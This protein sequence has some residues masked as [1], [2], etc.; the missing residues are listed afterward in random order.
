MLG[1]VAEAGAFEFTPTIEFTL[2]SSAVNTNTTLRTVVK[3]DTGEEELKTVK[4]QVPAEFNL[5]L[6]QQLTNG[7]TLGTGSI[8]I[9]V[10]PRCRGAGPLSAPANVPVTIKERDR[11]AAETSSG[12]VAI[13]VV[14]IQGVTSIPLSVY[15]SKEAGWRLEGPVP[16]NADTCPPFTFD[17]TFAAKAATSGAPI[18]TTPE[19]GGTYTLNAEFVGLQDS[20]SK[21][22]Q[23][24]KIEGPAEP[25]KKGDDPG[26]TITVKDEELQKKKKRCKRIKNKKKRRKCL[27][28]LKR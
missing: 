8:T 2:G 19:F 17:A 5:A 28:G 18:L 6:D 9:D 26:G 16:P 13:Y 25:G 21:H 24:V 20:V 22:E 10:G 11:S 12:V 15:G 7:E 23:Q 14:D 3:Q 1:L 27:Q 4:L